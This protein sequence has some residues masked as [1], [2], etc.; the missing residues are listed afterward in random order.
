MSHVG[1]LLS[2]YLDGEVRP[3]EQALVGTHLATCE[4]CRV[5]LAD[6]HAA[7][8]ALRSLPVLEM[9]PGL[10]PAPP[11]EVVVPLR[12]RAAAWVAAAAAAIL[13]LVVGLATVL[14]PRAVPIPLEEVSNRHTARVS[15]DPVSGPVDLSGIEVV[16]T[17]GGR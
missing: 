15:L 10:A 11:P 13:V 3:E 5:E 16:E 12:R 1:E 2:A 4:E 17:G 9:P 7:R 6:L 14:A 8:A